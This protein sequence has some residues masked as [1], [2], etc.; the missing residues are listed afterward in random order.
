MESQPKRA[1]FTRGDLAFEKYGKPV[2]CPLT[3]HHLPNSSNHFI[4]LLL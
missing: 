3:K 4:V 2:L 1:I